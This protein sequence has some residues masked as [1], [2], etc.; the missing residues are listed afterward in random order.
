MELVKLY[1]DNFK[2]PADYIPLGTF[3]FCSNTITNVKYLIDDNG[4]KPLLI[5]GGDDAPRIWLYAKASN[6]EY[7][8]LIKD[9]KSL[10]DN[11]EVTIN[12]QSKTILVTAG[13]TIVKSILDVSY[14][15]VI[16]VKHLDLR[17]VGL[18]VYGDANQLTIGENK[19]VNNSVIGSENLIGMG[20]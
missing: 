3:K 13:K 5:G 17:S 8:E 4:F 9:N 20:K 11:F 7:V 6:Y 14:D 15:Q 12:E 16:E 19:F 18:N 2:V 1:L 10:L